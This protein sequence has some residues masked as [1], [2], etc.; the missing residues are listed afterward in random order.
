M[1]FGPRLSEPFKNAM[2]SLDIYNAIV[3]IVAPDG[4]WKTPRYANHL[5]AGQA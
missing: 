2:L 5:P 1:L 3:F 4:P